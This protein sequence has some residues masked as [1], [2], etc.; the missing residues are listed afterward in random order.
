MFITRNLTQQQNA[1]KKRVCY[2]GFNPYFCSALI[3]YNPYIPHEKIYNR[4]MC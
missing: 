1:N 4:N 2:Y 3:I